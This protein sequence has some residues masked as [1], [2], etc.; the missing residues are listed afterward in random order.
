MSTIDFK[1]QLRMQ[2]RFIESSAAAYDNGNKDEGIRIATT[3]RTLFH[4]TQKSTSLLYHLGVMHHVKV[5]ST[6]ARAQHVPTNGFF[7]NLTQ[8]LM[9][10]LEGILEFQPTLDNAKTKRFVKRDEWWEQDI[11]YLV[12]GAGSGTPFKTISRKDLVLRATNEDGG[13]H[14]NKDGKLDPTYDIISRLGAG[15]SMMCDPDTET[16]NITVQPDNLN[17]WQMPATGNKKKYVAKYGHVA[18]LRQ[19]AYEVLNSPELTRL[20]T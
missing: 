12:D 13:A 8:I 11:A 3:V 6:C 20:A 19:I 4:H 14:V 18:A 5:L 2:L 16:F 1:E 10:P 15:F 9:N 7:P 17:S